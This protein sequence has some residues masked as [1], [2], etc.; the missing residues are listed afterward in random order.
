METQCIK[1]ILEVNITIQTPKFM[2]PS[3]QYHYTR[4]Q[5]WKYGK[6][7]EKLPR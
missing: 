6:E 5:E 2:Q 4:L 7:Q 1:S 3:S